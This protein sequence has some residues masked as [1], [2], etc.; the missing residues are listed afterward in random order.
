[1]LL[2]GNDF[3]HRRRL[4]VPRRITKSRQ[5]HVPLETTQSIFSK[6]RWSVLP[7]SPRSYNAELGILEHC[8]DRENSPYGAKRTL[9]QQYGCMG[10]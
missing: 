1:M 3:V 7:L 10:D 2:H 5:H 4:L 8:L 6:P 9:S